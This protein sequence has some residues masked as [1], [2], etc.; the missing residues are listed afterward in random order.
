[1]LIGTM[2]VA[3][4]RAM[5]KQPMPL[6]GRTCFAGRVFRHQIRAS[7]AKL[8]RTVGGT[9]QE[10]ER[11]A[12]DAG[13]LIPAFSRCGGYPP[14]GSAGGCCSLGGAGWAATGAPGGACLVSDIEVNQS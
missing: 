3:R 9:A 8:S 10:L 12:R 14:V 6:P 11:Q 1:M 13:P 5:L 4:C 7:P 2:A